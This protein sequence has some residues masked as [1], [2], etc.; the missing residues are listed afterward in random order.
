MVH[1]DNSLTFPE[2]VLETAGQVLQVPHAPC[3]CRLSPDCLHTPVVCT[4]FP[5]LA[6]ESRN[7]S[8]RVTLDNVSAS[9]DM[10]CI[11]SLILLE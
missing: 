4:T 2:A 6:I 7:P 9:W 1:A 11:S 5:Q 3:A 10:S 8:R